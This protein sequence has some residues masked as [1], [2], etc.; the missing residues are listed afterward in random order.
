MQE[1]KPQDNETHDETPAVNKN[2][3]ISEDY[4]LAT[5]LTMRA[6]TGNHVKFEFIRSIDE[7]R[8]ARLYNKGILKILS[9]YKVAAKEALREYRTSLREGKED[10]IDLI[11][12]RDFLRCV[13]FYQEEL[14]LSSYMIREY[15][16][17]ILQGHI[18][19]TIRGV[20]RPEEDLYDHSRGSVTR[21]F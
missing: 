19:D 12:H 21:I 15:G 4:R 5:A 7:Y 8:V 2:R 16:D 18:M 3:A 13:K 17:Y 6:L 11:N 14:C 20:Y 1:Y 10:V 9:G